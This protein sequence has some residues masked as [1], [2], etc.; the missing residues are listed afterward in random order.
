M[1]GASAAETVDSG[2]I[3]GWVKPKTIK[4]GI[5]SYCSFSVWCSVIKGTGWSF[6]G[7]WKNVSRWQLDSKTGRSLRCF[8][9]QENWWQNFNHNF[10]PLPCFWYWIIKYKRINYRGYVIKMS[11]YVIYGKYW[12]RNGQNSESS[13]GKPQNWKIK[14]K[15]FEEK[16]NHHKKNERDG[17][18][19]P[20]PPCKIGLICYS[21]SC[22]VEVQKIMNC[23]KML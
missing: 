15:N 16:N 18:C 5:H 13:F 21:I 19:T 6:H 9:T 20:Y 17:I 7:V 3:P 14:R 12:P 22:I 2:L 23:R 8:L 1:D 10:F 11:Y 4:I